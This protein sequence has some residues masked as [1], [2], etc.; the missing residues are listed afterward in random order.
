MA[1]VAQT[2]TANGASSADIRGPFCTDG[3]GREYGR[4]LRRSERGA[5]AEA[6]KSIGSQEQ[7][8]AV[9]PAA[10]QVADSSTDVVRFRE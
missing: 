3:A 8:R 2:L 1:S 5:L 9:P 4:L 6:L 10:E 7:D